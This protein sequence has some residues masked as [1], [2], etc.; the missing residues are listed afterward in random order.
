MIS[1]TDEQLEAFEAELNE[2]LREMFVPYDKLHAEEEGNDEI[3]GFGELEKEEIEVFVVGKCDEDTGIYEFQEIRVRDPEAGDRSQFDYL[4]FSLDERKFHF[5]ADHRE[6]KSLIDF[7]QRE[8]KYD[9][10]MHILDYAYGDL[11]DH[12]SKKLFN[13][14]LDAAPDEEYEALIKELQK[15]LLSDEEA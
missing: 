5:S 10:R 7:A 15:R 3:Y 12:S 4:K 2:E 6:L 13:M 14:L 8:E 9:N 1:F 11:S